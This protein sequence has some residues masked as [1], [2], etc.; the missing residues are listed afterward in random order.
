MSGTALTA[1]DILILPSDAMVDLAKG[2]NALLRESD[3]TGFALDENHAPHITLLQRYVRTDHLSEVNDAVDA[4]LAAVS[5][6]DLTL[7]AV[8]L[9]QM[10]VAAL[11]GIG[12]AGVLVQAGPAVI[13][14]QGALIEAIKPFMGSGGTSAAYVTSEPDINDDTLR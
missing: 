1:I 4:T 8:E 9:A 10:E 2:W 13:D 14:L 6:D 12:L 5:F 3:P 11:P 7:T